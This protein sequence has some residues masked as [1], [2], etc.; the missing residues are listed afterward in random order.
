M[1]KW[2]PQDMPDLSGKSAVITGANSGIGFEVACEL[3][4]HG[5][6]VVMACRDLEKAKISQQ[7]LLCLVPNAEVDVALLDISDLSSV[8]A[9]AEEFTRHHN[10]LS[11]LINNAGVISLPYSKTK[12]GIET[13]FATNYL[14][15]FA[16]TNYLFPLLARDTNARI[17]MTS[18]LYH[19]Q[20]HLDINNLQ[21]S[22][23]HYNKMQAYANSKIAC[24]L[25]TEELHRRLEAAHLPIKSVAAHPG[26]AKT[27]ILLAEPEKNHA[28]CKKFFFS[29]GMSLFAQSAEKGAYPVLY[30]ATSPEVNCGDYYG[31]DG[32]KEMQGYPKLLHALGQ[33]YDAKLAQQLWKQSEQLIGNNFIVAAPES[34]DYLENYTQ[35]KP[36][37]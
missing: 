24:L 29:L 22:K 6:A 3:A 23:D 9:F 34:Q 21:S 32:F 31:P 1:K 10:S 14:G 11:L 26:W 25:F 16:L 20:G 2:T 7:K 13:V 27:H 12:D 30:A 28:H 37:V 33:V 4:K 15:H 18:S 17:L 35:R 36:N 5:C 8:R 19:K